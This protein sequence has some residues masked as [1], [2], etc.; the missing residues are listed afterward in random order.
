MFDA[1]SH[2]QY[3]AFDS[4]REAVIL[5]AREKNIKMIVVGTDY[6]MSIAA[7]ELAEKYPKDIWATVGLHPN[8]IDNGFDKNKFLELAQHK[9]VV[10]IGECGLDYYRNQENQKSNIK[11]QKEVFRQQIEIAQ[12]LNKPLMI[13]ARASKGADD[14]YEDVLEFLQSSDFQ[15]PTIFHFYAGSLGVTKKLVSAG[16]YFTFGGVITFTLDYDEQ[17]KYIPLDR[18]MLETDAPYVAPVPY[19]GKRNEPSFVSEVSK[20]LAEIKGITY[21]K[22]VAITLAT[23][24][25]V[26]VI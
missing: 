17:I 3:S 13:H 9:K 5:R 23:T 21:D 24:K 4:D 1:H 16:Y 8:D 22:C 10:A 6:K 19:R 18:I 20:R 11:N 14:A 15:L 7:I 2:I 25:K 26:F 12:E